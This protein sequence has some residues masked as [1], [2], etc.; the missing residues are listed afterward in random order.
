M[1]DAPEPGGPCKR[2]GCRRG[3]RGESGCP[4]DQGSAELG[5]HGGERSSI[6]GSLPRLDRVVAGQP[7][8][9][10]RQKSHFSQI[11]ERKRSALFPRGGLEAPPSPPD[12]LLSP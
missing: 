3:A 1:L 7:A 10:G 2:R 12:L 6:P 5:S 9:G 11:S 8:E 4:G